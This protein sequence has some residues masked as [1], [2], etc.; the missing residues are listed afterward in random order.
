MKVVTNY[1]IA[2][3]KNMLLLHDEMPIGNIANRLEITHR[4]LDKLFKQLVGMTPT[5]YRRKHHG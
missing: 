4:G 3:A 1:R 2:A 5:E